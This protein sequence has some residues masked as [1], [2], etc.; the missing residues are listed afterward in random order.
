MAGRACFDCSCLCENTQK[1]WCGWQAVPAL[2]A[3]VYALSHKRRAAV[4]LM[5]ASWERRPQ[6][7]N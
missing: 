5:H 2:I 3:L 7:F 4:L 1:A 6:C